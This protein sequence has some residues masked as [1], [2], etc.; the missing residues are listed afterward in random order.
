[1]VKRDPIAYLSGYELCEMCGDDIEAC[2]CP[3]CDICTLQGD[4][5]CYLP[6]HAGGHGIPYTYLQYRSLTTFQASARA[7]LAKEDRFWDDKFIEE[8]F[9]HT[10]YSINTPFQ[11]I[12]YC[13]EIHRQC[14]FTIATAISD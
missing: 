4:P 14:L 7:E 1:M 13:S 5:M 9:N 2:K 6:I 12:Q 8:M 11:S 3:E 10:P